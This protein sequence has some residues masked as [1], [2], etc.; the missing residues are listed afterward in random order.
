MIRIIRIARLCNSTLPTHRAGLLG[1]VGRV[2][3]LIA[4]TSS[5][6]G[7]GSA[8]VGCASAQRARPVKAVADKSPTA[9][10]MNYEF[11]GDPTLVRTG[12]CSLK[13]SNVTENKQYTLNLKKD[14]KTV[15]AELPPGRYFGHR[16]TCTL[17][18]LYD[19]ESLFG[20]G[21]VIEP[22]HVSYVG[23]VIFEFTK[24]DLKLYKYAPRTDSHTSLKQ[25]LDHISPVVQTNL[26]SGFTGKPITPEMIRNESLENF[27][28]V[29]KG[30]NEAERVLSDL[31]TRLNNCNTSA[32]KQDPLRI[33][34][35]EYIAVYKSGQFV[36]MQ[37]QVE[38]S[39]LSD[40]FK[41]CIDNSLR[42]FAP[43]IKSDL[44][45]KTVF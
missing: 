40:N 22:D 12:G 23:K 28:V 17:T 9:I 32:I 10:L 4:C 5:L 7:F 8:L 6:V 18:K 16:L 13:L 3:T 1:Q 25:T 14:E 19:L 21:F 36:R 30:T 39:A 44:E 24:D 45:V 41:L 38:S 15:F 11:A 37:S 43:P 33:G 42:S 35:L 34:H 27:R 2:A 29:A 20:L 31:V 26:I